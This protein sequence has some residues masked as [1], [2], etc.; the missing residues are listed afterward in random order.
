M[1]NIIDYTA[2]WIYLHRF[3]RKVAKTRPEF[4]SPHQRWLAERSRQRYDLSPHKVDFSPV[5]TGE[6]GVI[7]GFRIYT[8][9]ALPSVNTQVQDKGDN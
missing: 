9:S 5:F 7:E 3:P 1:S 8:T 2:N 6:I 4:W